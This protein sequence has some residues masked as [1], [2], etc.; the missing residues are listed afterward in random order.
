MEYHEEKRREET[1]MNFSDD[2]GKSDRNHSSFQSLIQIVSSSTG[3]ESLMHV[4]RFARLVLLSALC[5]AVLLVVAPSVQ[6]LSFT[7]A[8]P[9]PC[10]RIT[11]FTPRSGTPGTGVTLTGCGFTGATS[12]AFHGVVATFTVNSDTQITTSVPG[13]ALSGPITVTTSNIT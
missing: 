11:G 4:L 12:V 6:A 8:Q 7:H 2:Q 13:G 9:L 10:P 5:L 3:K 1:H